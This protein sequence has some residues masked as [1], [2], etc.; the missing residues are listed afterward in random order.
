M[1]Q[2]E[3]KRSGPIIEQQLNIQQSIDK[4]LD[5]FS[6][7]RLTQAEE[8][9]QQVLDLVSDEPQFLN[10]L[11]VVAFQIGNKEQ[12]LEIIAILETYSSSR[13]FLKRLLLAMKT[14][15]KLT[16]NMLMPI[17]TRLSHL[18]NLAV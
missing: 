9:F 3:G 2:G 10:M 12:A 14:H 18:K 13:A 4:I 17:I 6:Q 11:G 15:S 5:D 8:L 7:N 1:Q 16:Q